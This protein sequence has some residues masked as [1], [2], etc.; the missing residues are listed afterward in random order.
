MGSLLNKHYR[1][2]NATWA[3]DLCTIRCTWHTIKCLTIVMEES[4]DIHTRFD[5][6]QP[7]MYNQTNSRHLGLCLYYT[8]CSSICTYI[9]SLAQVCYV[10]ENPTCSASIRWASIRW[11]LFKESLVLQLK[12]SWGIGRQPV[13]TLGALSRLPYGYHHNTFI[14]QVDVPLT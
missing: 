13:V 11:A 3:C 6:L 2:S 14:A 12:Q 1:P 10:V 7:I 9:L 5:Q 4:T 8:V